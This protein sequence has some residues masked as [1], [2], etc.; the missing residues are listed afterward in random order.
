[1]EL[2]HS[3]GFSKNIYNEFDLRINEGFIGQA[4]I[5]KDIQLYRDLPDDTVYYVRTFLGMIKPRSLMVVPVYAN[6]EPAG[7]LVCASIYDYEQDDRDLIGLMRHY[8]G[9]AVING[10]NFEKTKRLANELN[11]QNKLIQ[12]QYEEMRKRLDEKTQLAKSLVNYTGKQ[13]LFALDNQGIVLV[14]SRDAEHI[15]GI[16]EKAAVNK[17]VERIYEENGWPSIAEAFHNALQNKSHTERFWR[18]TGDG[19]R[20]EY[21]YKMDCIYNS[22]DVIGAVMVSVKPIN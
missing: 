16:S 9:M 18:L 12:E 5:K 11:F 14:W 17:P 8:L 19:N 10:A 13:G 20:C 15:H 4:L 7:I 6:E 3:V 1:L 21:E 22:P 2:K